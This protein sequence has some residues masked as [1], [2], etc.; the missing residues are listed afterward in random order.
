[1]IRVRVRVKVRLLFDYWQVGSK[2]LD[3]H[4][5]INMLLKFEEYKQRRETGDTCSLITCLRSR[6]TGSNETF[7]VRAARRETIGVLAVM[8]KGRIL[9]TRHRDHLH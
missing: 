6:S 1:M 4:R 2:G 7:G 9:D 5:R 8:S 3:A